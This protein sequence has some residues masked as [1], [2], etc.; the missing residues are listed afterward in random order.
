MQ[1]DVLKAGQS[2]PTVPAAGKNASDDPKLREACEQ[3]EAL[4]I[5][6]MLDAMRKSIDKSDQLL[7][8]GMAEDVFEDML[9]DEYSKTMAKTGK[10]GISDMLFSQLSST[11]V[12]TRPLGYK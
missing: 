5:K 7:N 11:P 4:F 10:F 1:L 9:Y 2:I 12:S 6:Q 8:G 3:F